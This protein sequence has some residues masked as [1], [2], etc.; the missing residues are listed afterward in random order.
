MKFEVTMK[1]TEMEEDIAKQEKLLERS[2]YIL[3]NVNRLIYD[4][5]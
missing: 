1:I 5:E 3:S 2:N 4:K